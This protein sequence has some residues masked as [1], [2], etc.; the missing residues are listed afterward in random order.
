MARL[1][2]K[3]KKGLPPPPAPPRR[4]ANPW[5]F[6]KTARKRDPESRA[7]ASIEDIL[8]GIVVTGEP[9]SQASRPQE[10]R[11]EEPP[12][13]E[14]MEPPEKQGSGA[15]PLFILLIAIGIVV[16]VVSQG[17]ETGDWR[18]IVAPLIA[19]AFIAHGWWRIRQRRQQKK[20]AER[21]GRSTG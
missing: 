15:W 13:H 8:E 10:T 6:S 4:S 11:H 3:G 12:H 9:Q 19:I 18:E 2:D 5:K 21:E 20:Q 1:E 7:P 17:F 16:K 14:P